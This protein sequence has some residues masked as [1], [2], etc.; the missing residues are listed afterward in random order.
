MKSLLCIAVGV[1]LVASATV[2]WAVSGSAASP[3]VTTVT[4]GGACG[5]ETA[6]SNATF[7]Q[8][9]NRIVMTPG[10]RTLA[11]YDPHGIGV[12]LAWKDPGDGW[13]EKSIFDNGADEG[14]SDRPASIALDGAGRAW[15]VWSGYNFDQITPVKMR[16]LTKLDAA[17][18]PAVG[19]TKTVQG[20]GMG[21]AG[22]D[23][24][25]RRGR[26]HIVWLRRTGGEEY[27]LVTA[28]F[29]NLDNPTPALRKT[30]LHTGSSD[31]TSATLV[32]TPAGMRAVARTGRLRL[33]KY[34]SASGWS[35]AAA[36]MV[37]PPEARPSA[38]AFGDGVLVA[39]Q[40]SSAPGRV[41]VAKFSERGTRV[42]MSLETEEGYVQP[43]I[44]TGRKRAWI[45]MVRVA[46]GTSVVSRTFKDS[47]WKGDVTRVT[48]A[49]ADDGAFTWPNT[50]RRFDGVLR[51]VVGQRCTEA[52]R[53][54]RSAVLS[55]ARRV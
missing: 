35:L 42:R 10:G 25:F 43:A 37:A 9:N 52:S 50:H 14:P 38:V 33:F 17:R 29:T 3:G 7:D 11:V 44:A 32:S 54:Q 5:A 16:R 40:S 13:R 55:F 24:A 41:K 34:R 36:R 18:G 12:V 27:R 1:F 49:S 22:V 51:F 53:L 8:N 21:N 2:G 26:G 4:P 47:S 30:V 28:S 23:L 20:A 39:W 15:V 46:S 31:E 19:P 45:V 6:S 48:K